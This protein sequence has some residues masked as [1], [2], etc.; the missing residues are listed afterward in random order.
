MHGTFSGRG[1]LLALTLAALLGVGGCGSSQH[2]V[3][4]KVLFNGSPLNKPNGQIVF[5]G[6][7]GAQVAADIAPDGAYRATGVSAGKNHVA[8]Y[9]PNPRAK[10]KPATRPKPGEPTLPPESAFLTPGKY[11]SAETSG[12]SV[13]VASGTVF[14]PEM[15]GPK[16]P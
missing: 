16:I 9:Y 8:V 15:H 10:A 4:G 13:D 11:A 2:D 3:S 14:N 7:T 1:P 5:V 6:P 12:F